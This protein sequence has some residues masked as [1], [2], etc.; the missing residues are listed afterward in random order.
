MR[1]FEYVS[2][3]T[4]EQAVALLSPTRGETAVLAGGTDLLAMMKDDVMA[5][6]RVVNLKAIDGLGHITFKRGAGLRLGALVTIQQLIGHD[7]VRRTFPALVTAAA[8]IKSPQIRAMGTVGGDLCQRPRCWFF[9]SGHGLLALAGD[10]RSLVVRG[11]N[12][13][14]AILGN[15]GPAYFVNPSSLAPALIALGAEVVIFGPA[16]SRT[17][18]AEKF[19]TTPRSPRE[20]ENVLAP[21]EIVTQIRVPD[22]EGSLNAAY[23]VR[24]RKVIDWPLAAAAVSLR[25][26]GGIVRS[27]RVVLGHVAPV[28]WR[29]PEAEITLLGRTVTE[30]VAEEAGAAAVARAKALSGNGYKIRLARVAVKRTIL[31]TQRG[32]A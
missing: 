32:G 8:G 17:I 30:Q 3:T 16:G 7:G 20:Q 5:P 13:Y 21:D 27:A 18:A 24:P 22:P 4:R 10:G 6:G 9:R 26:E 15:S 1:S 29:S 12:R 23:E 19:H 11:D 14:H 31:A 2:P 25:E 28:P